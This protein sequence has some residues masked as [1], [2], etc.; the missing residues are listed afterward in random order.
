MLITAPGAR[1]KP[2]VKSLTI[3]GVKIEKPIIKHAQLV[4]WEN[5]SEEIRVEYEMSDR[6]EVWGNDK[7][8]LDVLGVVVEVEK[9]N[10][11][12]DEL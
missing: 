7:E 9:Q 3:N 6:V 2:Y 5:E 11:Q 8:V 10:R 4:G 12:H 1:R